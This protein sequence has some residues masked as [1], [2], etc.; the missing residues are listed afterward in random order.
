MRLKARALIVAPGIDDAL[1]AIPEHFGSEV[2]DQGN[3][4]AGQPKICHDLLVMNRCQSLK[5]FD[6]D[7]HASFDNDID[8]E[9]ISN[10]RPAITD[11]DVNLRFDF[12]TLGAKR[13]SQKGFIGRLK[14]ASADLGVNF[15]PAIDNRFGCH[16]DALV[17]LRRMIRYLW[18]FGPLGETL[19]HSGFFRRS[20]SITSSRLIAPIIQPSP[21]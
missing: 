19:T 2:R 8:P 4:Q 5:R 10:E 18:F 21:K 15:E 9:R 3:R 20:S 1:D 6:L 14:Q 16:F 12:E 7:D 11:R 17:S 13:S